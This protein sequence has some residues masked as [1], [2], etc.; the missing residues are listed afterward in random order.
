[1]STKPGIAEHSRKANI[2]LAIFL[3]YAVA[4]VCAC[5]WSFVSFGALG[6]INTAIMV[7]GG[8]F[9]GMVWGLITYFYKAPGWLSTTAP[10]YAFIVGSILAILTALIF[11]F[12][13]PSMHLLVGYILVYS[14]G[15][16]LLPLWAWVYVNNHRP[17]PK[18]SRN[19]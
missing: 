8:S 1:M 9:A 3:S 18:D 7:L 10:F 13:T 17:K 12:R 19:P 16:G 14:L 15:V 2:I 4:L 6:G 11:P 5:T